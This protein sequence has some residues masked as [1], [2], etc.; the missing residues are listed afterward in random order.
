VEYLVDGM[1]RRHVVPL[2]STPPDFY[3]S[4]PQAALISVDSVDVSK[5]EPGKLANAGLLKVDVR[6][7]GENVCT[8]NC[9][10][11]VEERGGE[12]TREIYSPFE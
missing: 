7:G 11:M 12:F 1:L 6:E 9:V 2:A 8:I 5:V 4:G 10:V 3:D